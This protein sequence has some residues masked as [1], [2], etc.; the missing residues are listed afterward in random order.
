MLSIYKGD[1]MEGSDYGDLIFH[2][3]E[4]LKSIFMEACQKLS[5]IYIKRGELRQ[6]EEILRRASAAEPYNEKLCLELLKLYMFQG[7]RSKAVKLYYSFKKRLKQELDICVAFFQTK[8]YLFAQDS[9]LV[10]SM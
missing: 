9:I 1:L 5:S 7:R 6:A 8:V 3:R 10:P 4:R 2:E